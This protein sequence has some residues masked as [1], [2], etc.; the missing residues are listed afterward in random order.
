MVCMR[1]ARTLVILVIAWAFSVAAAAA[2]SPIDTGLLLFTG[3]CALCHAEGGTGAIMLSWRLGK[4]HSLL[5]DRTDLR[6][7]YVTAIVRSGLRS[8]PPLTRVEVTDEQLRAIAAY[9]SRT[10]RNFA[11]RHAP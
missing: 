10:R 2:D 11:A 1:A 7:P 3:K 5:A 8:M 4:N 9:L 6:A